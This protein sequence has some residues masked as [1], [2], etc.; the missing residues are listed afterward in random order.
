MIDH[1]SDDIDRQTGVTSAQL[2]N[3]MMESQ[4]WPPEQM[5]AYQRLQLCQ[6]LIHA[7][8][9]T[10]FYKDRL[11]PVFDQ[12]G[13]VDLARWQELPILTRKDLQSHHDA[14]RSHAPIK[15]HGRVGTT[16][17][18]GSTGQNV[19]VDYTS[20]A[21]EVSMSAWTRFCSWHGVDLGDGFTQ[22]RAYSPD[23][24]VIKKGMVLASSAQNNSQRIWIKRNLSTARKLHYLRKSK[25][26]NFTDFSNHAELLAR[27]N[28]RSKDP[29]R[30]KAFIGY[31]MQITPQQETLINESFQA[32]TLS[33][34]SS[35]ESTLMA[36][37]CGDE[38]NN[39]HICSELNIFEVLD[40]NNRPVP[41]G[42]SGRV[43]STPL[44]SSAQPLIRYDQ[45]D[46]VVRGP[47][48][49]CGRSLPV[50]SEIRGRKDAIF[51]FPGKQVS[52]NR[53]DDDLVQKSLNADAYQFAQIAPTQ[54]V[55]RYVS[56]KKAN[57]KEQMA[58]RTHL[59]NMIKTKIEITFCRVKEIPT[60]A[61]GKPQRIT[62][63][64]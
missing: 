7:R 43:I 22:I 23:G 49:K 4:Y 44:F 10:E 64:F 20:L 38:R 36:C 28:L 26:I 16:S 58:V 13:N 51:Q 42:A 50:L 63:E 34:Y 12:K 17:T 32:I 35:E 15:N 27:Q 52:M 3:L 9:T 39:F 19:K 46:I 30:F 60:N 59:L 8:N 55:V 48:C 53:L 24:S 25:T 47:P 11:A 6:L 5:L 45:G 40:E 18:S 61:G 21:I 41:V 33:P 56:P 1:F 54:I 29:V 31:G 37:Q 57:D 62:R 2:L 14:M